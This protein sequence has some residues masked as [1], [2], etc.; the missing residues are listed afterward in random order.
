MYD[1]GVIFPEPTPLVGNILPLFTLQVVI[2]KIQAT[3]NGY[4]YVFSKK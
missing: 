1:H 2:I 3:L 4:T